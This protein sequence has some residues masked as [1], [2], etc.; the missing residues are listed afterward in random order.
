[1]VAAVEVAISHTPAE[2]L[3]L[4]ELAG[5]AFMADLEMPHRL[6]FLLVAVV[7]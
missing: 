7:Q 1:M 3:Y 2:L 5:L 4:V 6:E